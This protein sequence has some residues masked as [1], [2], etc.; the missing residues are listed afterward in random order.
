MPEWW[1]GRHDRF[2]ICCF[3]A[4]RFESGLG[5]HTELTGKY[6][7]WLGVVWM[8]CSVLGPVWGPFLMRICFAM[9]NAFNCRNL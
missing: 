4:C 9:L 6:D 5:Y 2:K 1:N 3:A 7:E 8:A